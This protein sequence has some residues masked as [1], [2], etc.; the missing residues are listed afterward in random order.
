M[1]VIAIIGVLATIAV[2]FFK[3]YKVRAENCAGEALAK[4]I[5]NSESALNSDISAYGVLLTNFTLQNPPVCKNIT[6]VVLGSQRAYTAATATTVGCLITGTYTAS[7]GAVSISAVG[8]TIPYRQ[9]ARTATNKNSSGTLD[10]QTY[11]IITEPY[12]GN[13]AF[14]I[15]SDMPGH[16]YFV[17]NDNW[18]NLGGIDCTPPLT[19]VA[20]SCDFDPTGK[21]TGVDGGGAPTKPW[22]ILK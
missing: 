10:N 15:D 12:A 11:H 21:D 2:P 7:T 22:H 3:T 17:Q 6:T 20:T 1:V 5:N 13:R 4:Q 8:Q 16:M 19:N 18:T 9:D 14:G